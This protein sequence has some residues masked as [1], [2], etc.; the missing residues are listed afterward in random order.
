M[1]ILKYCLTD[2]LNIT[3]YRQ[4]EHNLSKTYHAGIIFTDSGYLPAYTKIQR[5]EKKLIIIDRQR[6]WDDG[7]VVIFLVTNAEKNG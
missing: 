4:I 2:R 6:L 3:S 5:F 1:K 7:P